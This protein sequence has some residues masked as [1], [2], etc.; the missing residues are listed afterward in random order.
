MKIQ[1]LLLKKRESKDFEIIQGST[2]QISADPLHHLSD[3]SFLQSKP[4][5]QVKIDH[6][7]PNLSGGHVGLGGCLHG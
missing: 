6:S 7:A 3:V 4:N 1:K 2:H 5:L